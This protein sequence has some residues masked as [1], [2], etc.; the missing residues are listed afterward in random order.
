MDSTY[1]FMPRAF[2]RNKPV[3]TAPEAAALPSEKLLSKSR[4]DADQQTSMQIIPATAP[5]IKG[6]LKKPMP[7]KYI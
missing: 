3:S 4:G 6:I 2:W 1:T 5:Q 7:M